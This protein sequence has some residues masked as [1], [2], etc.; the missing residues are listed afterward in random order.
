[1]NSIHTK[2]LDTNTCEQVPLMT[3]VEDE[4][5]A[6]PQG[7]NEQ[8]KQL[9]L[10]FCEGVTDEGVEQLQQALSELNDIQR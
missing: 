7:N 9:M 6:H 5:L 8:L 4:H 1:M 3:V 10:T 2:S